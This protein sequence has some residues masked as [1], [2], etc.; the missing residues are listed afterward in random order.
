[1]CS[2]GAR[3]VGAATRAICSPDLLALP[4]WHWK[5]KHAVPIEGIV[6]LMVGD[7][8]Q[9]YFNT[10][11]AYIVCASVIAVAVYLST[12]FS[13]AA[14]QIWF[15]TRFAFAIALWQSFQDWRRA[16]AEKRAKKLFDR[17]SGQDRRSPLADDRRALS[18]QINLTKPMHAAASVDNR[19][20]PIRPPQA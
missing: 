11:G 5:W 18:S 10:V 7:L 19:H 4:P 15:A 17:R 12:A 6:G 9:R 20:A 8:L 16:L 3:G 1:M 2:P 14:A 13:F